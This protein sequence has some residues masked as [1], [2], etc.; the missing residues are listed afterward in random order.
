MLSLT[1][2][3]LEYAVAVARHGGVTAAAEALHVSQPALSVALSHLEAT[4]GRPLFL[5]RAG[6]RVLPSSFGRVWLEQAEAQLAGLARL[7]HAE[8]AG[9]EPRLLIFQD[10]APTCLA[11]ILA[12]AAR[13]GIAIAP[14][15]LGFEALAEALHQGRGDLALTWDLG[16]EIGIERKVLAR[17]APH[18]V[19][20]A[21]HALAR[22]ATLTLADLAGQPLV[23]ADQGLSLGHMRALFSQHGLTARIA[24]RTASLE[25]LRSYAANGLGIGISYT[26]PA[27]RH[28]QDGQALVTRPIL[29]AGSEPL[30]LARLAGN[31]LSQGAAALAALIPVTLP[32]TPFR[33]SML[34]NQT[35]EEPWR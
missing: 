28:S 22:Q 5:R 3:Q 10:I 31:P 15:V 4:L 14:Q 9:A 35:P 20:A 34:P 30:V 12:Q 16:L 21:D 13:Q 17:V 24:H 1:L 26:N 7:T 6:G 23:L 32:L 33:T 19:L 27:A 25:L 8:D 2:R 11:P 29:D 18:A